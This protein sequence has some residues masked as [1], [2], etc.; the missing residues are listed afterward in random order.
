LGIF[1]KKNAE[2]HGNFSCSVSATDLVEA[3]KDAARLL[4]Y[5]RKKI[6]WLGGDVISGGLLGHHA[7]HF[8]LVVMISIE[9]RNTMIFNTLRAGV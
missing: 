1:G 9:S 5:T 4:V 7:E 8:I 6:F 2:M 3:S